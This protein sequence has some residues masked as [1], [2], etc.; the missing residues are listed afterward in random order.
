MQ[1][2]P[3]TYEDTFTTVEAFMKALKAWRGNGKH[4]IFYAGT[5]QGME[6]RLKTYGHTYLQIF[7]VNHA[8]RSLPPTDCNV[9]TFNAAIDKGLELR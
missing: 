2:H 7:T 1:S 6:V 8:P 9:T 5:V 4:W 3:S